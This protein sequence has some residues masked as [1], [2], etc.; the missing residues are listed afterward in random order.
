MYLRTFSV[1]Y[2]IYERVFAL[3]LEI[4]VVLAIAPQLSE[5]LSTNMTIICQG[6][7]LL[8]SSI[9]VLFLYKVTCARKKFSNLVRKA[10]HQTIATMYSGG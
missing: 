2:H 1:K 3:G 10:T 4:H 7:G 6:F 5:M 8:A 9:V